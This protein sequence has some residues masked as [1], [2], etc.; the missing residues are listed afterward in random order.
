MNKEFYTCEYCFKEYEPKRRRIQI[1]CSNTCRS[2]AF[3]ARKTGQK[4]LTN[5]TPQEI[6][7]KVPDLSTTPNK[8]KI[9]SV[10]LPGVGNA[11]LGSLAA[12]GLISILTPEEKKPATKA[13]IK[14]LS[15]K[16]IKR[17]HL[18]ENLPKGVDG[19]IPYFDM[20]T[21]NIVYSIW[22]L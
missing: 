19:A 6:G 10:S 11:A 16:I 12:D 15:D 9:Q 1:Y 5:I 17:Y 8:T 2:K 3:H 21:K 4:E 13:D 22:P 20:E 14:N 7:I 18:V